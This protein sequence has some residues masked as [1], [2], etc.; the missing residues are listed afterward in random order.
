MIT[1]QELRLAAYR[2]LALR[3]STKRISSRTLAE[4]IGVHS[5]QIRRDLA[6][7]GVPGLRGQGYLVE[8]VE[9]SIY[10]ILEPLWPQLLEAAKTQRRLA[11]MIID[12]GMNVT[13]NYPYEES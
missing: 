1:Q 13:V 5:S 7:I 8:L 11:Q 9:T 12:A 4:A 3:S 10:L 2:A 6:D